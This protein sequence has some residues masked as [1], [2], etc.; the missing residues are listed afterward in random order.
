MP[1]IFIETNANKI[2][3]FDLSGGNCNEGREGGWLK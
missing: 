3:E 2:K 1:Q